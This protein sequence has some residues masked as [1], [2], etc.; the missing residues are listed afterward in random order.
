VTPSR[1]GSKKQ[2]R[3]CSS[4]LLPASSPFPFCS[5]FF[6][7]P[8]FPSTDAPGCSTVS[9]R[10]WNS[11]NSSVASSYESRKYLRQRDSGGLTDSFCTACTPEKLDE[12]LSSTLSSSP[13]VLDERRRIPFTLL[14][15]RMDGE[16][17]GR[18]RCGSSCFIMRR[19]WI[20]GQW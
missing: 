5:L 9:C 8:L 17:R 14:Q 20:S 3:T 13:T 1:V 19:P 16:R 15:C 7:E 12:T 4:L 11:V 6:P 18:D 2:E 10:G